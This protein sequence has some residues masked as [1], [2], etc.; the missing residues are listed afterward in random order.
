MTYYEGP[1][2]GTHLYWES[3]DTKWE[4][5]PM[6]V[7]YNYTNTVYN[8]VMDLKLLYSYSGHYWRYIAYKNTRYK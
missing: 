5:Y 8:T 6:K 1:V 3:I 4:K 7:R 2:R